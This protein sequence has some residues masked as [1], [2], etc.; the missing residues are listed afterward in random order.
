M[1]IAYNAKNDVAYITLLHS[2]KGVT[3]VTSYKEF[4]HGIIDYDAEGQAVGIEINSFAKNLNKGSIDI[5][6]ELLK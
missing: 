4:T 1:R 6:V 2:K 5:P 3:K